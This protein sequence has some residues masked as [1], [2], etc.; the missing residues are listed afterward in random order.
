MAQAS[1]TRT[2]ADYSRV[3]AALRGDRLLQN[4]QKAVEKAVTPEKKREAQAEFELVERDR[5]AFHESRVYG[6]PVSQ[7]QSQSA[8]GAPMPT[9]R[10]QLQAGTVYNTAKGPARWNGERFEPVQ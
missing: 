10:D 2:T 7:G 4:A 5:R 3:E 6:T 8:T 1:A 9:S